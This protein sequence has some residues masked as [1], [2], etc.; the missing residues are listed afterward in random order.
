MLSIDVTVLEIL[1]SKRIRR[2]KKLELKV[3]IKLF[4]ESEIS[5]FNKSIGESFFWINLF[6]I[7][8]IKEK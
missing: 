1:V 5:Y 7:S 6:E 3:S 4:I 2:N 8:V